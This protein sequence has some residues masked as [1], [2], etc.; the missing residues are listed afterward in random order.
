MVSGASCYLARLH[1]AVAYQSLF[2]LSA[3]D[4][5][6]AAINAAPQW[7][8][9][10]DYSSRVLFPS[11]SWPIILT[12]Q[13]GSCSHHYFNLRPCSGY[14]WICKAYTH[15]DSCEG[16]KSLNTSLGSFKPRRGESLTSR[17]LADVACG[18]LALWIITPHHC[19]SIPVCQL[20][21]KTYGV[22]SHG[23]PYVL[24]L[25]LWLIWRRFCDMWMV[26]PRLDPKHAVWNPLGVSTSFIPIPFANLQFACFGNC[27]RLNK[28][29]A[30][31]RFRPSR[32]PLGSMWRSI[33]ISRRLSL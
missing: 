7:L 27:P 22:Q 3:I 26:Y 5:Q 32:S 25:V 6:V 14:I 23:Y 10:T 2:C 19:N 13:H 30:E 24:L 16:P 1:Q 18:R 28:M 12:L 8:S 15:Q 33:R 20:A 21:H 11:H 17:C 31:C 9:P 29:S 4:L